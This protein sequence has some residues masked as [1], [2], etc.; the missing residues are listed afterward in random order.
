MNTK[1]I[2]YFIV[3]ILV[4]LFFATSCMNSSK[5][6]VIPV[7]LTVEYLTNPTGLDVE[8]P[9]FSWILEPTKKNE[10]GQKQNAYRILV[11]SNPKLLKADEADVWDT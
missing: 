1:N 9:R 6:S 2:I 7:N 3:S 10:Y 5:S 8:Q 11:A 4:T